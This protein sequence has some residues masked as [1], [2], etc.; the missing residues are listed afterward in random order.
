M[1]FDGGVVRR[2]A[3][4]NS[5]ELVPSSGI[6][7][8]CLAPNDSMIAYGSGQ[9]PSSPVSGIIPGERGPTFPT[10]GNFAGWLGIE[11]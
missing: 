1:V 3:E 7:F 5:E 4:G 11:R 8:A 10:E 6:A 2:D 9:P